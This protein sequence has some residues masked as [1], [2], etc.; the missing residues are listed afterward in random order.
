MNVANLQIEGLL[1]AQ[2]ALHRLLV[3]KG[4][5]TAEEIE[6]A[7]HV[8]EAGLGGEERS[9]EQLTPASRDAVAFPLRLLRQAALRPMSDPL[10]FSELATQ[11]GRE[12]PRYNDQM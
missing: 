3:A 7:L 10:S 11:V 1:M 4:L 12:K 6:A 8:A 9:V 2:A 5:A